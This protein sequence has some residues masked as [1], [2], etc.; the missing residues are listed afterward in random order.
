[1]SASKPKLRIGS[2]SGKPVEKLMDAQ[3]MRGKGSSAARHGKK[4]KC[5]TFWVT[6]DFKARV[7]A[8]AD[9]H[10]ISISRLIVEGLE[11]R[12]KRK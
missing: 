2:A 8:Y 4:N 3:D 7:A 6:E 11:M 5:M 1:M 9:E 10:E 12:M